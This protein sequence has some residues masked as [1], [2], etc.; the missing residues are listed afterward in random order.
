[1]TTDT[2]STKEVTRRVYLMFGMSALALGA[3]FFLPAGTLAYWH[4]WVYLGLLLIPM[5]FVLRY[6]VRN[7]PQLLERR[8]QMRER[9]T[10]QKRLIAFTSI[11]F[12]AVFALPGF[13]FR[14]GWSDMPV[15]VVLVGDLLV[16]LSYGLI[17]R[18]FGENR[19]ASR[20]VEVAAGQQVIST[21]PYA[22]VR[23]PMYVGVLVMYMAS[24]IALGSWWALLPAAVIL[25]ILILRIINEEQVLERDLPGYREYKLKTRYRLVPGIW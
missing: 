18:V 6:L 22:V 5:G 25:P 24:P 7:S 1:M 19:Y 3:L 13:D 11:Y 2:V 4:G 17:I 20:T 15:W 21:G 23:H 10:T 9:E 12:L 16:L 8:M 14:W